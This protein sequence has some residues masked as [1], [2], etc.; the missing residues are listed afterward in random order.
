M[1][2]ILKASINIK[3]DDNKFIIIINTNKM[4]VLIINMINMIVKKIWNTFE[5]E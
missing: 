3:L 1:I 4:I 5:L 2:S